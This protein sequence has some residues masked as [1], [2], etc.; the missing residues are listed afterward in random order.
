MGRPASAM[1]AMPQQGRCQGWAE[2]KTRVNEP[3]AAPASAYRGRAG[4]K[5]GEIQSPN[6]GGSQIFAPSKLDFE[7]RI[8]TQFHPRASTLLNFIFRGCENAAPPVVRVVD[9]L[10][11]SNHPTQHQGQF[12]AARRPLGSSAR[13]WHIQ[14]AVTWNSMERRT[15]NLYRLT[16]AGRERNRGFRRN[17]RIALEALGPTFSESRAKEALARLKVSGQLGKGTPASFWL[18]FT[19]QGAHSHKTPFIERIPN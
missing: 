17:A 8:S 7:F 15:M 13:I 2:R 5:S 10:E 3:L 6:D 11:V 9:P 16:E 19:A 12:L 1:Q 18:R 14:G 4:Q